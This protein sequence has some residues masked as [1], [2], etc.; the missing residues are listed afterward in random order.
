M[1]SSAIYEIL[2]EFY[3]SPPDRYFTVHGNET[4]SYDNIAPDFIVN[5][6][7][8]GTYFREVKSLRKAFDTGLSKNY[9]WYWG[10]LIKERISVSPLL[11]STAMEIEAFEDRL[12]TAA[13]IGDFSMV[14]EVGSIPHRK[15][16]ELHFENE[17]KEVNAR[18][19]LPLAA[20]EP[21]KAIN[22]QPQDAELTLQVKDLLQNKIGFSKHPI[23]IRDFRGSRLMISDI[24]LF[25]P[26][27]SP[28][29]EQILPVIEIQGV[30]LTPSPSH[31]VHKTIPLYCY[32]EIYNLKTSGITEEYEIVYKLTTH[33]KQESL[34]SISCKSEKSD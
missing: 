10:E 1:V 28:I 3:D 34:F 30:L 7:A 21:E 20:H 5:F 8:E 6:V 27:R 18:R 31:Q 19:D 14:P 13:A 26:I 2:T 12:K 24:Q 29:H 32:F 16:I 22:A 17:F 15:I 25:A 9:S 33:K 11:A 23:T 4:W